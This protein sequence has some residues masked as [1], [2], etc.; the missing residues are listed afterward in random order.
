MSIPADS[1]TYLLPATVTPRIKSLAILS[2]LAVLSGCATTSASRPVHLSP[3]SVAE[4]AD[5][6]PTAADIPRGQVRLVEVGDG[7]WI[8]IA[9]QEFAGRVYPANGMIVRDGDGLLLIDTAWGDDNTRALLDAI[10]TQIGL[11]VRRSVSMHFHDDCVQGVAV[12]A[13]AGVDTFASAQTRALAEASGSQVPA[14]ALEGLSDVGDAMPFGPVELFYPGP[15]HAPDNLVAYVPGARVLFGGC[16]VH[17][18][19]R[20]TAGNI[21]DADLPAWPNAIRRIQARYPDARL[22]IPGHGLPAGPEL[23]D[24]TIAIVQLQP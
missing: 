16:A 4:I 7:V 8:H 3:P 2:T 11:P 24:H 12:L 23:L 1:R 18:Q 17:E 10:R 13:D 6:Y 5:G 14:H 9:T 21:A 20:T 15:G 22:I 19:D